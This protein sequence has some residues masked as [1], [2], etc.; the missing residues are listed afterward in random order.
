MSENGLEFYSDDSTSDPN[1]V[2][3]HDCEEFSESYSVVVEYD[4]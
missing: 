2:L 1:Y 3:N 4:S